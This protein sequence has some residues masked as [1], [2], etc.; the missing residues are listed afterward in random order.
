MSVL[1]D[2]T[3]A[4]F[5]RLTADEAEALRGALDVAYFKPG[6]TII[7]QGAAPEGLYVIIKGAVEERAHGELVGLLGPGDFFD[8]RALVQG[9]GVSGFVAREET[10]CAL[11][12]RPELLRL[13]NSNPRFGAFF[14]TDISR[15]LEALA[16]RDESNQIESMMRARV[17]DLYL[18]PAAIIDSDQ[19][20]VSAGRIMRD[21]DCNALLVRDGERTGI[22][23]GMNLA[24]AVVL[25]GS[26][27]DEP[28]GRIAQYDLVAIE[29]DEFVS[30]ALLL[31]TKHNKR[32]VVVK[33]GDDFV[34]ILEDINLLSFF[35]GNSQLVVGRIDRAA[36]VPELAVAAKQIAEQVRPLRRQG[37]KFEVVAEI[38]S[39]LNRRLF[40]KLFELLCPLELRDKCCLIVMGSEG[41]GEQTIRTDQDNGLILAGPVDEKALDRFRNEFSGALAEFG[42]PP[43]PGDVMVNN[44]LWSRTFAEYVADFGLWTTAPDDQSAMNVAIFYDAEAVAGDATLLERAKKVLMEK[45]AGERVFL[46]RF[47]KAIEAFEP[48]IGLFNTLKTSEGEGDA[49]DLKK[50]GIFPIVHGVRSLAIEQGLEETNTFKRLAK[51]AELGLLRESFARDLARALD[52]L[53]TIRLDAQIDA[54][55]SASLLKPATLTSMDRDLLRDSFQVVKQLRE[56]VRRRFNLAMF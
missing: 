26:T 32:R 25:N 11:A 44:P 15:R 9:A 48:P 14:Y 5:D 49:L 47:A 43:C 13:I 1:L 55:K 35:A 2:T 28:V 52:Y 53:M 20:I 22:V 24:K 27:I 42:F 50:G 18:M 33:K 37:V 3:T 17:R 30:Q 4:P 34:G 12:P 40:A 46:G 21:I 10:L 19:P 29:P 45:V 6:E 7:A 56:L 38:I 23:T 8:S 16:E 31:M 54:A 36:T 51:L 39:D 41:R